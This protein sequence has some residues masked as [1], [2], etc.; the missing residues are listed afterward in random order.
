MVLSGED[1]RITTVSAGRP[2]EPRHFTATV[3]DVFKSGMSEYDSNLV[4]CN[5]E[6]LQQTR[7]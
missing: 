2:P 4:F 5:L 1:V 6:E 7:A 3:V